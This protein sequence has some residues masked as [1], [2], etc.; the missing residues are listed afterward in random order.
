MVHT[1]RQEYFV[2][3]G[4]YGRIGIQDDWSISTTWYKI[5]FPY[6][7]LVYFK[8]CGFLKGRWTSISLFKLPFIPVF[9][10]PWRR[11]CLL[12]SPACNS[13]N[14]R[15]IPEV[16]CDHAVDCAPAITL[17]GPE[18]VARNGSFEQAEK[19]W[20]ITQN[21]RIQR[22]TQP[23]DWSISWRVSQLVSQNVRVNHSLRYFENTIAQ[24]RKLGLI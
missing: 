16:H 4:T 13:S 23:V 8:R 5:F 9:A 14:P 22:V 10:T 15:N 21:V 1:V 24:S 18:V 11:T 12:G 6:C 17:S 19:P 2:P 7:V 20:E 3:R